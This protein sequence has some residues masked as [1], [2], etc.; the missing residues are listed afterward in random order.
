MAARVLDADGAGVGV[1]G[2]GE[3]TAPP[4]VLVLDGV[5]VPGA[6]ATRG[7][8]PVVAWAGP[9]PLQERWW[10]PAASPDGPPG[11]SSTTTRP[12][13]WCSKRAAGG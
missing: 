1:T 13:C 2:R 11:W 12:G 8:R 3:L 7:A 5:A 6:G 10:D 4:A 9:W